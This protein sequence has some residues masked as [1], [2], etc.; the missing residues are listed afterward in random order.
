MEN[1]F[2]IINI[3]PSLLFEN[4][5]KIDSMWKISTNPFLIEN[6]WD[7]ENFY[8][9]KFLIYLINFHRKRE[10]KFID[11]ELFQLKANIE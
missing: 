3:H 7:D 1:Y 4:I 5:I 10:N 11:R 6:K 9:S 8:R 2:Q